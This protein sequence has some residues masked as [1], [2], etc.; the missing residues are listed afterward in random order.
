[1]KTFTKVF[2][3]SARI[4]CI[5]AVIWAIL[6]AFQEF[7]YYSF[8]SDRTFWKNATACLI[9]FIPSFILVAILII[10]MK[11]EKAG[12]IIL[13]IVGLALC[14]FTFILNLNR[15]EPVDTSLSTALIF[16]GPF[17]VAGILFIISHYRKKKEISTVQ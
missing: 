9:H 15:T 17:I 5:L 2:H 7:F 13:L 6:F 10:A 14:I 8:S 3:W 1:M 12:G 16:Y 11:Y 4:L